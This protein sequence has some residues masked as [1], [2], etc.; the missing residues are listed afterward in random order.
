MR[1]SLKALLKAG[2]VDYPT[3]PREEWLFGHA[4]QVVLACAGIFWA[5]EVIYAFDHD[6]TGAFP[7]NP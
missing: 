3:R 6:N 5:R 4:S 1:A 7:Y 2:C